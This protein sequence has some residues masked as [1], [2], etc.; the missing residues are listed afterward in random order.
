[1][2]LFFL[3]HGE[4]GDPWPGGDDSLRPLT[5]DGIRKLELE[6]ATLLHWNL[7][8]DLIVTS[9]F[10]RARQTADIVAKTLNLPLREDKRLTAGALR[11][12]EIR[13]IVVEHHTLN[14][15]M[16]VGHEPDFSTALRTLTGGRCQL[17][18]G[19]L[20]QVRVSDDSTPATLICL[21]TPA[22]L[23]GV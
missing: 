15:M 19:G 23:G 7:G 22:Q 3:R 16:L 2:N 9:P 20:A 18:K 14:N 1:M 8:L 21:L 11:S 12:S 10:L 4:A 17:K 13:D 5:D 6:A